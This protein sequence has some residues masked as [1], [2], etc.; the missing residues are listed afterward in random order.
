M[1]YI[2]G[3][4]MSLIGVGV[5]GILHDAFLSS[6]ISNQKKFYC[7][8]N[9][10]IYGLFIIIKGLQIETLIFCLMVSLLLIISMI[11]YHFY[12]I[13]V[14]FNYYL[15]ALGILYLFID[16]QNMGEHLRGFFSVSLLLLFVAFVSDGRMGG[17]DVKLM[18]VCGLI[19]GEERIIKSFYVACVVVCLIY[20][21]KILLGKEQDKIAMGPYFIVGIC[22]VI[23]HN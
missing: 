3:I 7:L 23:L 21:I 13:P 12:V 19:L 18:A 8:S 9:G 11:D 1:R 17:G 5:G 6:Y 20:F 15:L 14:K 10:F 4:V 22:L 2:I 16:Y